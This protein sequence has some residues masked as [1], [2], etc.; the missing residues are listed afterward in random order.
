MQPS[1]RRRRS[2][3]PSEQR[4]RDLQLDKLR[5]WDASV[6]PK[7]RPALRPFPADNADEMVSK[8][9]AI[10]DKLSPALGAEFATLEKGRN[11]D[12][13]SRKAKR[14]GGY[15]SSLEESREPFIFMNAV[16]L[17]DDVMT[18]LHEAGHA[19]HAFAAHEQ[20]LIWQRHPGSEAAELASMSMELLAGPHLGQPV[21][22]LPLADGELAAA[23]VGEPALLGRVRRDRVCVR[24]RDRDAQL[25][26]LLRGLLLACSTHGLPRLGHERVSARR[27]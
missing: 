21:G 23:L 7:N 8:C 2:G 27:A 3:E 13:E 14:P 1:A 20:P 5:P 17:V 15:Q 10:F 9:K 12:L 25:L 24:T 4:R 6:D 18:L 16:G 22:Q 11:L 26:G 19:F